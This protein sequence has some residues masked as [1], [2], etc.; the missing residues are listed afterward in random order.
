MPRQTRIGT[1]IYIQ[2]LGQKQSVIR[3]EN[4]CRAD[5][6]LAHMVS[7]GQPPVE[8]HLRRWYYN[9]GAAEGTCGDETIQTS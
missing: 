3:Q 8:D 1:K 9:V 5:G 2:V 4:G 6:K 7:V